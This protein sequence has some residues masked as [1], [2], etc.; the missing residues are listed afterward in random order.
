MP[1]C[2]YT[3]KEVPTASTML[4][5]TSGINDLWGINVP[6]GHDG[7]K[8]LATCIESATPMTKTCNF[9]IVDLKVE[10]VQCWSSFSGQDIICG[11]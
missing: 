1:A 5:L 8:K 6:P 4:T 2:A 3:F 10:Y 11:Q 9:Y 7:W